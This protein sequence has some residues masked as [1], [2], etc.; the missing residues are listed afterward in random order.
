M[1]GK[2][3]VIISTSDAE[4]ARTGAMYAVN[5]LKYGWMAEVKIFF[6]GPA[7]AL[8]LE[9]AELQNYVKEYQAMEE[10]AVACK[11]ISDRDNQSKQTCALGL[12]V[13][14][15]GKMISDLINEGF[16]PMVW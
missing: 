5:A 15:V 13:E 2:L 12:K 10:S 14:Y 4:K 6:F 7:Q 1:D 16:V 9:D 11:Y 8:L 3:V